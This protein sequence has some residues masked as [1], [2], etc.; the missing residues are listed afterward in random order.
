[1]A[2]AKSAVAH[3]SRSIYRQFPELDG[4]APVV[5]EQ[6][7]PQAKS[8]G[9][10]GGASRYL[11]TYTHDAALPNGKRIKR[12]VRVVAGE[13]GRVIRVSTSR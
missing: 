9:W 10:R 1:M 6:D 2:L 12:V 11:L 5:S 4:V 8:A 7:T 13:N 3:I